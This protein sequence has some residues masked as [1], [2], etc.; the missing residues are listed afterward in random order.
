[1]SIPRNFWPTLLDKIEEGRVIP[2]IGASL[3]Q[4][5]LDGW[6]APLEAHLARL[7][8][9]RLDLPGDD[10]QAEIP[11]L[12]DVVARAH[13]ADCEGDYHSMVHRL[14]RELGS[15][16]APSP[17]LTQLARISGFRLYLNLGFDNL[18]LRALDEERG[19]T[20]PESQHLAYAPNQTRLDLPRAYS[21]LDQPFVY[22][23]FGKSCPAPEFVIS[24]EDLL[25]WVTA[26]QDPDNRPPQLF[27]ALRGNHLLF[28]GCDL[29]DW[30]LRFF[31][32]LT[33]DNRF[34]FSR[35]RETLI[36]LRSVEHVHL[37]SFLDQ[38]SPKTQ[39]LELEPAAFVAELESQWQARHAVA[40]STK[41]T[42]ALPPDVRPGGVFL[43]YASDDVAAAD[44]LYSALQER[45]IDTWFDA[46][47]LVSG[48]SYD[49]VIDRNIG[50]CGVFLVVLSEATLV[51]LALWR[52]R[53]GYH[54]EKKPYFLREWEL[55]LSRR[56]LHAEGLV[57]MPV[58]IDA[59]NLGDPLIPEALRALTCAPAPG[60][61]A[62][63]ALFD[64]I[65]QGVRDARRLRREVA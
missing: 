9:E 22:A 46:R 5:E 13:R 59:P 3:V 35:A 23:L 54:P 2:V 21:S 49:E 41:P 57:L 63:P 44:R 42:V 24:E 4:V 56:K 51:R 60:G 18:L 34:S 28:I 62:D 19:L 27:D 43:S 31:I 1:M 26:L 58:R 20:Q 25:E 15:R 39:H 6:R 65:R 7:L 32:R 38:F 40:A 11:R 16:V 53:D 64:Q 8:A 33:R 36:G 55:A 61:E 52:D 37:V 45:L 12:F 48:A 10:N 14:L 29:P 47:R 17:A 50:R 30:L